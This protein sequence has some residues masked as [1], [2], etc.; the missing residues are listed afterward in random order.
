MMGIQI[1][2]GHGG[3]FDYQ[4]SGNTFYGSYTYASN[5]AVGIVM[6]GAGYSLNSTVFIASR[7]ANMFSSNAGAPQQAAAWKNGWNAAMSGAC[8][9]R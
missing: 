5:Y 9:G 2:I 8:G 7:F 1:G 3:I 6:N 4:R